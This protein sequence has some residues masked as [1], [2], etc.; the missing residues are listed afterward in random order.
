MTTD[1]TTQLVVQITPVEGNEV[2][3][4]ADAAVV[5]NGG[6]CEG[7]QLVGFS[8]WRNKRGTGVNITFPSRAYTNAKGEKRT[9]SFIQ[10]ATRNLAGF[11]ALIVAAY[12]ATTETKGKLPTGE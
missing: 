10:G 4:L 8:V 5:F 12:E 1:N 7:C 2:G 6:P 9:F 3:R 11:R